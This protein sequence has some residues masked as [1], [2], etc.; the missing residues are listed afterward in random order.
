MNGFERIGGANLNGSS[1]GEDIEAELANLRKRDR[2]NMLVI[3]ILTAVMVA[4]GTVLYVAE[5]ADPVLRWGGKNSGGGFQSR[6]G[7]YAYYAGYRSQ[8]RETTGGITAGQGCCDQTAGGGSASG[9]GS[10]TVGNSAGGSGLLADLEKQALAQF[11]QE[12]GKSNVKAKAVD[13]GCHIQI[14]IYDAENKVVRS[15]GYQGGPL[16]VIK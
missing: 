4:A 10:C 9:L 7:V 3:G 14:D 5:K 2:R 6:D 16:Y 8:D 13:Y 1:V 11:R 12:T 15:Y